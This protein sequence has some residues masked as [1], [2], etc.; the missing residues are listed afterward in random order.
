ME[1]IFEGYQPDKNALEESL[2][3]TANGYIGIRA[4]P[5]EGQVQGIPSIRGTYMNAFYD[6]KPIRYGEKLYGFPET[7]QGIVN[8]TDVQTIRLFIEEEQFLPSSQGEVLGY[9]R[10]LDMKFG[11]SERFIHWRSP[12]GQEVEISI[13]RMASLFVPELFCLQYAVKALNFSGK[14]CFESIVLGDVS[15]YADASDPRVAAEKL[16]HL[17]VENVRMDEQSGLIESR[18]VTSNLKLAAAV[19][20]L[21]PHDFKL[22]MDG[23]ADSLTAKADGNILQGE[24]LVFT[25]F[26]A[27]ADSRRHDNPASKARQTVR[28]ALLNGVAFYEK[29]QREILDEFWEN[30]RVL[31][32]SDEAL[33]NSLDYSLYS[34]YCSCG[35]DEVSSIAAKGLSGEGYEGHYFWDTEIYIFPFF[36][37]TDRQRAKNLLSFRYSILPQ[38]REH[39]RIMGH[40]CGALYP[41][42]TISGSECSGYFPSGSAQYHLSADISHAFMQ[43]YLATEDID[44]MAQKGAEVLVETARLFLDAGHWYEGKFRIDAVT[45]PDEYSCIVDNNFYTNA[46]AQDTLRNAVIIT[47]MLIEQGKAEAVF[48][49]TGISS[50][51]LEQFLQAADQM[52]LPYDEKLMIHAQDDAFLKLAKLD[53]QSIP[54]DKYPLLLHYHPLWLYR[55]QV[56]KQA[57]TV[58]AHFLYEDLADIETMRRSYEYYESCTTH[59]SSLSR[60]VFS[61]MASKL[62]EMD[63]ALDYFRHSATMDIDD[64]HGNTKDGI[65]TANMGGSYL[66]IV[67]GFAGLRIKAS[68]LHLAPRIPAELEGYE[69]PFK[70]LNS[71]L[72]ITVDHS[73]CHIR[74]TG[75]P[76]VQIAVYNRSLQIGSEESI[77]IVIQR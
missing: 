15:N 48:R 56:C 13:R 67:A 30:S 22:Q 28:D 5:E 63:K 9:R 31:V 60:C 40:P 66:A 77:D 26:A 36:L 68:G 46:G 23:A 17:V 41:W 58:L 55:H 49:K 69:F 21:P 45:G 25:L 61:I 34:L 18:T 3:H 12:K 75:G 70:Y 71:R 44:F 7:Q 65:H 32:K 33:Q 2:F 29:A 19:S 37:L 62:G 35:R 59:D 16:R 64:A 24:N 52:Y 47:R 53:L 51:E 50:S 42:R 4:C 20:Y 8:L 76:A 11:F 74:L 54:P 38:A 43:Y 27:F 39:A 10:S 14:I 1:L 57:D 72:Y 6:I 73:S